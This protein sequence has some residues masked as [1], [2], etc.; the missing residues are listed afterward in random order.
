MRLTEGEDYIILWPRWHLERTEAKVQKMDDVRMWL[1]T[2]N[3]NEEHVR[4]TAREIGRAIVGMNRRQIKELE[5]VIVS[6]VSW[7]SLCR[8]KSKK[9]VFARTVLQ[10]AVEV[11]RGCTYSNKIAD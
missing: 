6:S 4:R 7:I 2:A 10:G 3:P 5:A 11:L 9:T 1:N 8:A